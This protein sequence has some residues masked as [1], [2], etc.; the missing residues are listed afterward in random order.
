MKLLVTFVLGALTGACLLWFGF[1]KVILKLNDTTLV[2][3]DR[4]TGKASKVFIS[5]LE[6]E[7][8]TTKE[9]A[10]IEA[11]SKNAT[12]EVKAES[13]PVSA[14]PEWR[15]L[16]ESEIKQLEFKWNTN[17]YGEKIAFGYHNPFAKPVQIERVRFQIPA[18]DDR[19]A[20][21]REY[22]AG[23]HVCA[24]QSDIVQT[25]NSMEFFTT[26]LRSSGNNSQGTAATL[27]PIRALILK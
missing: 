12:P 10:Q 22:Q 2:E 1:S 6:W 5:K 23:N 9:E 4:F 3:V 26:E 16:T 25:L 8:A 7:Q 21:D 11:R 13:P 27:V 15:E 14:Q 17:G 20:V 24:P 18:R 19:A